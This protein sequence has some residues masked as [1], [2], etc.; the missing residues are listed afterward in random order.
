MYNSSMSSKPMLLMT[1]SSYHARI[2]GIYNILKAAVERTFKLVRL[3]GRM[4]RPVAAIA[5]APT[6][7][8]KSNKA[9]EVNAP[10]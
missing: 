6:M 9:H 1:K 4:A 7:P 10:Y 3:Y 2:G 5:P 8:V